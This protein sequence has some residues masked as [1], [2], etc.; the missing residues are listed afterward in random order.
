[1]MY[2]FESR[3]LSRLR[4]ENPTS[5]MFSPVFL[6]RW[7]PSAT[8]CCNGSKAPCTNRSKE[9]SAAQT[10]RTRQSITYGVKIFR[11]SVVDLASNIGAHSGTWTTWCGN[12]LNEQIETARL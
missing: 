9:P 11:L 3:T 4:L 8:N 2:A 1:M 12:M 6:V 5:L 7:H 10:E